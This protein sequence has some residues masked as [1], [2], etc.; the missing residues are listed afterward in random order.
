MERFWPGDLLMGYVFGYVLF[1]GYV[2]S[3][4]FFL[5]FTF[6]ERDCHSL[7]FRYGPP[8]LLHF[9]SLTLES[10]SRVLRCLRR[11]LC[12]ICKRGRG[13]FCSG[14]PPRHPSPPSCPSSILGSLMFGWLTRGFSPLWFVLGPWLA[15]CFFFCCFFFRL[16]SLFLYVIWGP[17]LEE[18]PSLLRFCLPFSTSWSLSLAVAF[19]PSVCLV[20]FV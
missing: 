17:R 16:V 18:A 9:E 20:L 10:R 2:Y 5:A 13:P 11:R 14:M 15:A 8:V 7:V 1:R 12:A 3:G 19:A 4:C 6:H